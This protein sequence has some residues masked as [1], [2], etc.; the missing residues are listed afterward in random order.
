VRGVDTNVLV[1]FLTQDD[2]GQLRRVNS[3]FAGLERA[4]ETAHVSLVVLC[5]LV[6]VLRSLYGLKRDEIHESLE[7]VLDADHL[8]IEN[9]DAVHRAAALYAE[10]TGDF[11]DYLIGLQNR[12][13]GCRDTV[14]LDRSLR[15]SNLFTVL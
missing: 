3:F 6:W 15:S 4:G 2:P 7:A 9:R 5:E 13:A 8:E 12:Q 1:R 14:T 11:A 10:G